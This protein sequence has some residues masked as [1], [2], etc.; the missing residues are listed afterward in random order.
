MLQVGPGI[1]CSLLSYC[2]STAPCALERS[3][4]SVAPR[5]QA[6]G[7]SA[8]LARKPLRLSPCTYSGY[9][10]RYSLTLPTS[11]LISHI[12]VATTLLS[13]MSKYPRGVSGG[14]PWRPQAA[15]PRVLRGYIHG[16]IG[17]PVQARSTCNRH[18]SGLHRTVRLDWRITVPESQRVDANVHL[19]GPPDF[20][21]AARERR[22]VPEDADHAPVASVLPR[23]HPGVRLSPRAGMRAPAQPR[24][25][26]VSFP[27][28]SQ[29]RRRKE[30]S[31]RPDQ[32][33]A[34]LS[35]C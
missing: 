18:C 16:D 28:S 22:P 29:C 7:R 32:Y 10:I 21:P 15:R 26:R 8:K 25:E 33:V 23:A 11:G 20:P 13:T 5:A 19:D 24:P 1:S 9:C 17:V 12:L 6:K 34:G 4:S 31:D 14:K 27:N 2:S 30:P 3:S 35:R